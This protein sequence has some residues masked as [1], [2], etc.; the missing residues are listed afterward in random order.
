MKRQVLSRRTVLRGLIGGAAVS[1]GLPLLET[2]SPPLAWAGPEAPRRFGVWFWGNGVR[3]AHWIPSSTA[4]DWAAPEELQP[5]MGVRPYVSV[6]TGLEIK[7]A[8]HPH[9]SGMAGIMTGAR[10]HQNGITRDTIVSSFAYPSVDQVAAEHIGKQTPYRSLELGV[11]TFRGTDEGTTFQHLSHNGPNNV[12]PSDYSPV[13]VFKRLFGALPA[14]RDNRA[15]RS[16]LDAVTQQIK[17]LSGTVSAHDRVRLDQHLSSIR[18][19]EKRLAE[20]AMACQAPPAASD[21]PDQMG[22]EQ[23]EQKN[24]AMSDL[25]A[26]ALSCDL[27]RVFSVMFSCAGSGVVVW[28]A[29]ASNGLHQTCHD[30]PSPQPI[31]HKAVVF[32]MQQLAYFLQKLRDTPELGGNLLDHSAILCTTELSEG[33]THTNDEFPVLLAGKAGGKLRGGVHYRSPSK[34]NASKA[35]F[36]VLRAAG[37][38]LTKFGY[39]PGEVTSGITAVEG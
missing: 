33:N 22:R 7:T 3:R 26:V 29:G 25:L 31:V 10:Y 14:P 19:I 24:R 1:V 17:G 18:A 23:I 30:E 32:T 27:S 34:E 8:T 6:I 2:M 38:P 13:S 28:P 9:H 5:L 16:V 37:L 15:R 21:Y 36:T 39:G 12:N 35:L 20:D 11:C 4:P